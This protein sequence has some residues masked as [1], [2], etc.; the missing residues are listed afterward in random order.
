M[1]KNVFEAFLPLYYTTMWIIDIA[2][3]H[4]LACACYDQVDL[5]NEVAES[6]NAIYQFDDCHVII[7][8]KACS[9]GRENWNGRS[10][11]GSARQYA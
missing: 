10:T 2:S 6:I 9:T 11:G 5:N 8:P 7:L 3:A 4:N 1:L